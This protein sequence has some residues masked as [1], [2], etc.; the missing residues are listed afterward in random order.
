MANRQVMRTSQARKLFR[1]RSRA[2]LEYARAKAS[3]ATSSELSEFLKTEYATRY[4]SVEHSVSRAS[5][6]SLRSCSMLRSAPV[7]V[8]VYSCIGP[9]Q[10]ITQDAAGG[11]SV[12]S[13]GIPVRVPEIRGVR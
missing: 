5:N 9:S 2:K 4:A 1:S 12:Q 10:F 8:S 6:S 3:C 7:I 11:P 13:V